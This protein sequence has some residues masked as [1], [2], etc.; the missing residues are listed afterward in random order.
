MAT[1]AFASPLAMVVYRKLLAFAAHD[2]GNGD[3]YSDAAAAHAT[4]S[5]TEGEEEGERGHSS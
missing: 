3:G 1:G 2:G 5:E 4:E